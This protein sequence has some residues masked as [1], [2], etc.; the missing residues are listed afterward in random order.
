MTVSTNC[1]I[2]LEQIH[3]SERISIS[4]RP[5]AAREA[6]CLWMVSES[7]FHSRLTLLSFYQAHQA[8]LNV[9]RFVEAM[10]LQIAVY[11]SVIGHP[12]SGVPMLR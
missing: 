9:H 1:S 11:F 5:D 6:K 10:L 4:S 8:W 7:C 3:D 2:V 12:W